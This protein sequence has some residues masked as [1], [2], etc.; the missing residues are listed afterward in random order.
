[1]VIKSGAYLVYSHGESQ[2]RAWEPENKSINNINGKMLS[3]ER[4]KKVIQ[5]NLITIC[6]WVLY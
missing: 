2:K 4:L 1:M 5:C 3:E 6:C